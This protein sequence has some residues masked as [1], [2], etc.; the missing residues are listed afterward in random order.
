MCICQN[1][2]CVQR[3]PGAHGGPEEDIRFPGDALTDGCELGAGNRPRCSAEL[4][5]LWHSLFSTPLLLLVPQTEFSLVR[6]QS[7]FYI[8]SL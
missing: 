5:T 1:Y 4:P 6:E 3:V 8:P 7:C 2:V